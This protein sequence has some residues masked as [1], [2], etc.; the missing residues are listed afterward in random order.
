MIPFDPKDI[1]GPLLAINGFHPGCLKWCVMHTLNLGLVFVCN[2]G[3]LR[4]TLIQLTF[5]FSHKQGSA[6]HHFQKQMVCEHCPAIWLGLAKAFAMRGSSVVWTWWP[7]CAARWGI[8]ELPSILQRQ[9]NQA[10]PATISSKKRG[11]AWLWSYCLCFLEYEMSSCMAEPC[12]WFLYVARFDVC[13][14]DVSQ[15]KTCIIPT[16]CCFAFLAQVKKRTGEDLLTLKAYNGRCVVSWLSH[17]L[18][19]ALLL[20]PDNEILVLTSSCM[21]L[22]F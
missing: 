16:L 20:H 3:A 7:I 4:P 19:Q 21:T 8:S 17:S 2:G 10:I 9:Q 18:L 6:L 1:S 13:R 22:S 12:S 5:F 14:K 15:K 11:L